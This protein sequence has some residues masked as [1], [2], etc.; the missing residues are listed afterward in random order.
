MKCIIFLC[1]ATG[2]EDGTAEDTIQF[3]LKVKCTMNSNVSKV[4]TDRDELYLDHKGSN[5]LFIYYY[6]FIVRF[7]MGLVFLFITFFLHFFLSCTSSLSI[8]SSAI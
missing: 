2:D 8:S 5:N 7:P 1:T 6:L 4:V 3:S